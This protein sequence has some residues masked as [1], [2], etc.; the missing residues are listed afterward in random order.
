MKK[1]VGIIALTPLRREV[2][3]FV[4]ITSC[5][6]FV[7]IRFHILI[8]PYRSPCWLTIDDAEKISIRVFKFFSVSALRALGR[9]D[10]GGRRTRTVYCARDARARALKMLQKHYAYRAFLHYS[11]CSVSSL[12][13]DAT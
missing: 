4:H 1:W 12:I 10:A 7:W 5:G 13:I 8:D 6:L 11:M 9:L 2:Q 3:H